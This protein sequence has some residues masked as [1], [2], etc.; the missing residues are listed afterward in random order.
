MWT[1]VHKF[2]KC[3]ADCFKSELRHSAGICYCR[4]NMTW[5]KQS[6]GDVTRGHSDCLTFLL[7]VI[8]A[9]LHLKSV[10]NR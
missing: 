1:C 4:A 10:T 8:H 9:S 2:E 6:Y 3:T 5:N 7:I